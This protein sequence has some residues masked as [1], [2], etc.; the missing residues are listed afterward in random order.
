VVQAAI[1][2]QLLGPLLTL[3]EW[4]DLP[5]DVPGELIDGRLVEEEVPDYLDAMWAKLD[6]LEKQ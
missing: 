2:D 1:V 5:E 6:A 3:E 4:G